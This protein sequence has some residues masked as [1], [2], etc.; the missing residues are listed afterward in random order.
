MYAHFG[1]NKRGLALDAYVAGTHEPSVVHQLTAT[2]IDYARG[3]AFIHGD[4]IDVEIQVGNV[5]GVQIRQCAHD[6]HEDPQALAHPLVPAAAVHVRDALE[7]R[8][9]FAVLLDEVLQVLHHELAD[10]AVRER[11]EAPVGDKLGRDVL[12]VL[13]A[14][15]L[16]PDHVGV[17]ERCVDTAHLQLRHHADLVLDVVPLRDDLVAVHNLERHGNLQL[18]RVVHAEVNAREHEATPADGE[19]LVLAAQRDDALPRV[20]RHVV[21]GH[22]HLEGLG[23]RRDRGVRLGL[24]RWRI[25]VLLVLPGGEPDLHRRGRGLVKVQRGQNAA[26]VTSTVFR[27][28]MALYIL[29]A[30]RMGER[31]Q[32]LSS[33]GRK[34][35]LLRVCD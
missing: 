9:A 13:V 18:R 5:L 27:S 28:N 2:E 25:A 3:V 34:L 15:V 19:L 20:P 21:L 30:N 22:A 17:A 33:I 10:A 35:G 11:E 7:L 29:W 26:L 8:W 32:R 16:P 14:R 24:E 4:V 23:P 1:C 6:P 31:D 12:V